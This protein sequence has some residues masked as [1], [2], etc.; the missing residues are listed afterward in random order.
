M[1]VQVP[2]QTITLAGHGLD[3]PFP[4][5][6]R[7]YPFADAF[8]AFGSVPGIEEGGGVVL[9]AATNNNVHIGSRVILAG[10]PRGH[11]RGSPG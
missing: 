2:Q 10:A 3:Q 6:E 11:P 1:L 5:L 7:Q 8:A 4:A 9:D